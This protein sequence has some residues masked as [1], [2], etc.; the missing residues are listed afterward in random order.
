MSTR[1]KSDF[2]S[3]KILPEEL[4]DGAVPAAEGDGDP[5]PDRDWATGPDV[6]AAEGAHGDESSDGDAPDSG[7]EAGHR[8]V[9]QGAHFRDDPLARSDEPV[10]LDHRPRHGADD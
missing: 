8:P 7:T 1:D 4:D 9:E 5:H 3:G 6:A 2:G 10:E